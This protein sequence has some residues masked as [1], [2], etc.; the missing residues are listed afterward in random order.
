MSDDT[1]ANEESARPP[2]SA[3]Q[4]QVPDPYTALP[5][6]PATEEHLEKVELEVADVGDV[7]AQRDSL[8]R[9]TSAPVSPTGENVRNRNL[10]PRLRRTAVSGGR[11]S[12]PRLEPGGCLPV[13]RCL[14]SAPQRADGPA[15]PQPKWPV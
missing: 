7:V 5:E 15:R 2:D 9:R 10:G 12:D 8:R 4:I 11:A 14:R 6:Q 13:D 1:Q 3:P